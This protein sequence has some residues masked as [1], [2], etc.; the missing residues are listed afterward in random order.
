MNAASFGKLIRSVFSGLRTRR[1]GT[2]GNSKYHYYGIRIKPDSILN[3][4]MDEKPT[5]STHSGNG[6]SSG[7]GHSNTIGGV[8]SSS[9]AGASGGN[10]NVGNHGNRSL[11][12]MS[13]KPESY[14]T[15]AQVT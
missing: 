2:R 10:I 9:G 4:M 15:C 6:A 14:E 1:L 13:F 11:K 3:H 7:I 8:V 5:Y 12:K